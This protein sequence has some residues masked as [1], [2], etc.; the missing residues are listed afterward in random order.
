MTGR[1]RSVVT[2]ALVVVLVTAG[3]GS[4]VVPGGAPSPDR[5]T[6]TPA[7]LPNETDTAVADGRQQ[8]A[9]G[10]AADGLTDTLELM[11]AHRSV[12]R[13]TSWTLTVTHVQRY[14]NGTVRVRERRNIASA[15]NGSYHRVQ[16]VAGTVGGPPSRVEVWSNGSVRLVRAERGGTVAYRRLPAEG[17]TGGTRPSFALDED[18]AVQAEHQRLIA[19][20]LDTEDLRVDRLDRP[21]RESDRQQYRLRAT[22]FED[23]TF[24]TRDGLAVRLTEVD[25]RFVVDDRGVVHRARFAYTARADG[26]ELRVIERLR[27]TDL[28]STTVRPPTWLRTG[29]NETSSTG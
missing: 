24:V 23:D 2:V 22:E 4:D 19:I 11:A 10:L 29:L 1:S 18:V 14:G 7:P 8:V 20:L 25:I 5:A 16:Q 12:L 27:Y 15:A 21:H 26:R 6:L 28:G 9:P 3:C 17:T 13:N